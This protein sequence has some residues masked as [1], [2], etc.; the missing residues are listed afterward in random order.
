[1]G[2]KISERTKD[3]LAAAKRA[4]ERLGRNRGVKRPAKARAMAA[5]AITERAAT[6]AADIAPIIAEI[7]ARGATSLRTIASRAEC[8]R[9]SGRHA[10]ANGLPHRCGACSGG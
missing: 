7:K 6:R 5:A 1:L 9:H 4:G 2:L 8:S 3:V 10:A